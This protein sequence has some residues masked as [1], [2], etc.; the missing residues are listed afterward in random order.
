V[1][2]LRYVGRCRPAPY[3][4][5]RA[6]PDRDPPVTAPPARRRMPVRPSLSTWRPAATSTRRWRWAARRVTWGLVLTTRSVSQARRGGY[7]LGSFH[8][9]G[10]PTQVRGYGLHISDNMT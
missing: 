1:S 6:T 4:R 7:S 3:R 9:V 8:E 2:I 10:A 5:F